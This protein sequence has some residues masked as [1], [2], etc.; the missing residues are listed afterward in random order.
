M[1]ILGFTPSNNKIKQTPEQ[2]YLKELETLGHT[3]YI[4][5]S[6]EDIP[7]KNEI[8]VVASLSELT[9]EMAFKVASAYDIPLYSHF[10]WLPKW[11]IFKESE[12]DWGSIKPMQYYQK[13]NF[14]RMYQNYLYFWNFADCKSVAGKCFVKDVVDFI[15]IGTRLYPKYMGPNTTSI[16]KYLTEDRWKI[17]EDMITCVARF[18]PHKRIHHV[19]QAL[20]DIDYK[21]TLNLIGYGEEKAHYDTIKDSLNIQYHRSER[22]YEF[23]ER[24]T[25]NI[26]LWSGIVPAESMYL[27]VPCI[28][29]DSEYMEEL[30]GDALIYAHNN[31]IASLRTEIQKV[32][33]MSQEERTKLAEYGV[34]Q[35]EDGEINTLTL[36][37]SVFYLEKLLKLAINNRK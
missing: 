16:K 18:V 15:G 3:V 10:N 17:K 23:M 4:R 1:K 24:S 21:G 27:G 30:Y 5:D 19:I 9:A 37:N 35:I 25:V 12:M 28:T 22:K 7:S 13:M 8:D 31:D 11:R 36:E 29:Y 6:M 32:L 33:K 2:L 26:A 34:K 14:V 20:K